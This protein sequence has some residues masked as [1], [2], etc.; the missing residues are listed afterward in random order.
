MH[1]ASLGCWVLVPAKVECNE[2]ADLLEGCLAIRVYFFSHHN[3]SVQEQRVI[4]DARV[5]CAIT[6]HIVHCLC[7][8]QHYG[9]PEHLGRIYGLRHEE[10]QANLAL[11]GI[12]GPFE[13]RPQSHYLLETTVAVQHTSTIDV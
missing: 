8:S 12:A 5:M 10:L 11:F 9:P 13:F 6:D 2:V 1:C 3:L 7:L 4:V